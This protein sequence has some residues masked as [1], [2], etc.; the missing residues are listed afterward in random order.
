MARMIGELVSVTTGDQVRLDGFYHQSSQE[1][2]T[3]FDAAVISHGLGSNFYSSRLLK[4]LA[5]ELG[6]PLQVDGLTLMGESEDGMFHQIE[7]F[8]L[9]G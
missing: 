9:A 2:Q 7:R 6:Q 4:Y 5:A 3:A 8:A 1:R